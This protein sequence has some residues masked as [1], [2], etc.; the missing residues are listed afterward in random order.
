VS[1]MLLKGAL[2]LAP[3]P[4]VDLEPR[5]RHGSRRALERNDLTAFDDLHQKI[6]PFC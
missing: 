3:Q 4:C 1:A 2:D 5:R 6:G